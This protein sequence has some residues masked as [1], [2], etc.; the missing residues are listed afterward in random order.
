[1]HA[2]FTDPPRFWRQLVALTALLALL[3]AVLQPPPTA[4][5]GF[6]A[7]LLAWLL[8]IGI[9]MLCALA[10]TGA[11]LR[12]LPPL[13]RRPWLGLLSGGL[14]GGLVFAPLALGL[15]E[16]FPKG[17]VQPADDWLDHWEA[18]G[19]GRALV[20]E[21]VSL[22]PSYLAAWLLVN[23]AP[24]LRI[25]QP[26]L[27][28]Q[29][30]ARAVQDAA[31]QSVGPRLAPPESPPR[32]A[33]PAPSHAAIAD[34]AA[35][36]PSAADVA[37]SKP[38]VSEGLLDRLPLAVGRQLVSI[39]ADLH[40]LHVT[41]RRGRA[42]VLGSLAEA[43]S[44]LGQCGLR[45]HRSHWVALEAVR[46]L[47]RTASGWRCELLDGRSLPVSRRRAAEAKQRLGTDF[48]VEG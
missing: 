14:L 12:G 47:R 5:L 45:I 43:E 39:S 28:L 30:S 42:T 31:L 2:T 36:A 4:H 33:L 23:A 48:V 41:T 24:M 20:A 17:P 13:R 9:G 27:G 25:G 19:G 38:S 29:H 32:L 34:Q 46:R 44:E 8:H 40:Y 21:Y 15:E 37:N 16:L 11:L 18:A 7:A 10:A 6:L 3:F 22:L 1:M 26:Q 35:V